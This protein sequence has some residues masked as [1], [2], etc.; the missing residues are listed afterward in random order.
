MRSPLATFEHRR[1]LHA[2]A[3]RSGLAP[4]RPLAMLDG[5]ADT[6]GA[7][8][9]WVGASDLLD[10]FNL[11]RRPVNV[12]D[13]AHEP[14]TH[15]TL[16]VPAGD[17]L[18]RLQDDGLLAALLEASGTFRQV[19][20]FA[21]VCG[22]SSPGVHELLSQPNVFTFAHD[23]RSY[24]SIKH[25]GRAMLTFDPA[26]YVHEF[27]PPR[28]H[29]MAPYVEPVD[30]DLARERGEVLLAFSEERTSP[31]RMLTLTPDPTLNREVSLTADDL[32]EFLASIR[33]VDTVA[34]DQLYV[35]VAA[36]MTGKPVFY[37]DSA[38]GQ[39]FDSIDFV[40]GAAVAPRARSC[41]EKWLVERELVPPRSAT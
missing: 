14:A 35:A 33:A 12:E 24:E 17:A 28:D 39:I 5:H 40:F 20:L 13:V 18:T 15:E 9:T 25:Y 41:D 19:V 3:V 2:E 32:S 21:S 22:V 23:R 6:I 1:D 16:V 8:L 27:T 11:Q 10:S 38:D 36:V 31:L 26:L 34:T 29:D 30:F 4:R 37:V 7:R